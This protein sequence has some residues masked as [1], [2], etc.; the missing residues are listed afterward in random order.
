MNDHDSRLLS[1]I[2][3]DSAYTAPLLRVRAARE[4]AALLRGLRKQAG[5]TQQAIAARLG[6]SQARISQ[7][8][9]GVLDHLPPL[10]FIYLFTDACG[11]R[12]SL[13]A[14]EKNAAVA[15]APMQ[16]MAAGLAEEPAAERWPA[17]AD[18]GDASPVRVRTYRIS[19]H[20]TAFGPETI[21]RDIPDAGD[22]ALRHLDDNGIARIGA[23]LREGD[24]LVGKTTPDKDDSESRLLRAIFG[25]QASARDTSLRMPA[26]T[27]GT[28]VAVHDDSR[29]GERSVRVDVAIET[30]VAVSPATRAA[31]ARDAALEAIPE[32]LEILTREIE[33]RR[34][35][36]EAPASAASAEP[37]PEPPRT[38]KESG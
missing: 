28:V 21:T 26:G 27:S 34:P 20:D 23:H 16:D 7:V 9:S 6:V 13:H 19:T 29:S 15:A 11:A 18:A 12:L 36:M 33:S 30:N 5:L 25:K 3:Q 1:E 10:D 8:E 22:E 32:S 2:E 31:A 35:A 14:E 24:I 17:V 4:T 37:I 38:L